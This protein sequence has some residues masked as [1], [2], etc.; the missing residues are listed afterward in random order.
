MAGRDMKTVQHPPYIPDLTPCDFFL[1]PRIKDDVREFR[2]QSTKEI[3]KASKNFIKR[4]L[5]KNIKEV[6]QD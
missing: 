5:K 6:F 4:L 1:F 3:N 2:F